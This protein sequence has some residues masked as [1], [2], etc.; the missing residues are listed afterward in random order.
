MTLLDPFEMPI[1]DVRTYYEEFKDRHDS[2]DL[3]DW[4][5]RASLCLTLHERQFKSSA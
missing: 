4:I 1:E 5:A 3:L 2:V